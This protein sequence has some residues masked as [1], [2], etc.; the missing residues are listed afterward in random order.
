MV[1][2]NSTHNFNAMVVKKLKLVYA[3]LVMVA[4]KNKKRSEV[5][6]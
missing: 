1:F 2:F 3:S 6:I 4:L 5:V